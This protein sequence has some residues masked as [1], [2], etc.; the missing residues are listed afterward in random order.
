MAPSLASAASPTA[1]R[2]AFSPPSL[3]DLPKPELLLLLEG[4]KGDP[5]W[6]HLA[7]EGRIKVCRLFL[8][9]PLKNGGVRAKAVE[10]L[11]LASQTKPSEL[12]LASLLMVWELFREDNCKVLNAALYCSFCLLALL[13]P[14]INAFSLDRF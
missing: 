8:D 9:L 12:N 2:A 6:G 13:Q 14:V 1:L 5:R 11:R 3:E 4:L 7:L 10:I